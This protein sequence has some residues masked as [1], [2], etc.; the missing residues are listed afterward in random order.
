MSGRGA[1]VATGGCVCPTREWASVTSGN[2]AWHSSGVR[3]SPRAGGR[4]FFPQQPPQ[5]GRLVED[6]EAGQVVLQPRYRALVPGPELQVDDHQLLQ[7]GQ[8]QRALR[9]RSTA[10]DGQRLTFGPAAL[11]PMA[12][13]FI[14]GRQKR[15]GCHG[16][17]ASA[18]HAA[19]GRSPRRGRC[20][21]DGLKHAQ[22]SVITAAYS[23]AA[24]RSTHSTIR[25]EGCQDR[26]PRQARSSAALTIR[27]AFVFAFVPGQ[28]FPLPRARG[29][30]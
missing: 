19:P 12:A 11:E 1:S 18:M 4:G 8:E 23:E 2:R 3:G 26:L 27:G 13:I 17:P 24:P 9:R 6:R 21:S 28:E 5:P 16:S 30:E 7:R 25:F 10:L 14:D 15:F 20:S 29:E 22:D